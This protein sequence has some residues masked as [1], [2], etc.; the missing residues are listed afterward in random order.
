MSILD[1]FKQDAF[2]VTSLTESINKL[3]F[4][5]S[6]LGDMGLFQ[7]KGVTTITVAIEERN[8]QLSLIPSA[9]RGSMP[10]TESAPARNVRDLRAIHLPKNDAVMADEVQG[11]RAFGSE[12]E[13][14]T[15]SG[16][17]NDK[18]AA[19]RQDHEVTHEYHR[20]GAI[21]GSVLD[22]DGA[23]ELYNLFTLF[24]VS[25]VVVSFDF[26][27]GAQDMKL[28]ALEVER[29]IESALGGA[30]FSGIEGI[31][32]DQFFDRFVTHETVA[33]AYERKDDNKFARE[34]AQRGG[35][36]FGG[37]TWWNYR[38]SVGA[39]DFIPTA[40]CRFVVRGL[41]GLFV[42]YFAPADFTE[43]VNTKGKPVY[44]KQEPMKW[45]K[46]IEIHTQSNPL[47]ICTR[48]KSLIKGLDE[49]P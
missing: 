32:G 44:A 11:V 20:I 4:V 24:G 23:T 21:R 14:E 25:E 39:V 48:P 13:L 31:C 10:T 35:F 33:G 45:D 40:Q 37:I 28:K 30:T 46:G 3:P 8:G 47:F 16:V 7:V 6:K 42:N 38:G 43:T 5:P 36:D 18:M 12:S 17:V 29:A 9:A 2:K 41:P 27:A 34:K 26:T 49:T 19:L 15:I 1:V 22:A